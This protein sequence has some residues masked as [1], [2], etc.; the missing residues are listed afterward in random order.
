MLNHGFEFGRICVS[1]LKSAI[2]NFNLDK[3]VLLLSFPAIPSYE[4]FVKMEMEISE[5]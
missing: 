4:I 5:P 1:C 3:G 2:K